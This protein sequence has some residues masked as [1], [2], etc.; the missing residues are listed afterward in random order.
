MLERRHREHTE[1]ELVT[2]WSTPTRALS[3][4]TD[5]PTSIADGARTARMR[6]GKASGRRASR[7]TLFTVVLAMT[8]PSALLATP[9]FA[10]Q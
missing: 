7:R 1:K 4:F 10:Q 2:R 9:V 8:V 3:S 6:N 5:S